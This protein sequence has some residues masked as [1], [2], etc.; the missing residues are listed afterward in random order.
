MNITLQPKHQ[1]SILG[2][3]LEL[4]KS[5]DYHTAEIKPHLETMEKWEKKEYLEV[6]EGNVASFNNL[7]NYLN[8]EESTFNTIL[9]EYNLTVEEFINNL[10]Y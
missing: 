4:K 6:H 1:D 3:L 10:T 5:I 7:K 2:Q 8:D 9:S